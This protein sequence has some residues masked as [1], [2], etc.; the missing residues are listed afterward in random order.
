MYSPDELK[1][2]KNFRASNPWKGSY[3]EKYEKWNNLFNQLCKINCIDHPQKF[4]LGNTKIPIG[5]YCDKEI[6]C[7]RSLSARDLLI[8]F[9]NY[10]ILHQQSHGNQLDCFRY[11]SALFY[12]VWPEKICETSNTLI[13]D[14]PESI[15]I[16]EGLQIAMKQNPEYLQE[17]TFVERSQEEHQILEILKMLGIDFI[18][19]FE[20]PVHQH[21][22]HPLRVRYI[23]ENNAGNN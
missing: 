10:R 22:T 13:K 12:S 17:I 3:L 21:K 19:N 23:G 18:N 1:I 7:L 14:A 9:Y 2:L 8:L 15:A 16:Y 6:V 4:F 5:N 20:Q 11:C